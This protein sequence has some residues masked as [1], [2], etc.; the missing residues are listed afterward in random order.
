MKYILT[1]LFAVILFGAGCDTEVAT[2]PKQFPQ[3]A[4]R[5]VEDPEESIAPLSDFMDRRSITYN[6]GR[7]VNFLVIK[8]DQEEFSW[9]M[10]ED[11]SAPKT[12]MAW[13]QA[14]AANLVINGSYFDEL[15]QSTG[16]YHA[17]EATSTRI[18]WP[19]RDS[20]SDKVSYTGLVQ[21][22]NDELK[23][24]YLPNGWQKEA[25]PDVAAFLSFPTLINDG[26]S[27]VETDSGKFAH[28]TVLVQDMNDVPYIVITESGS[29]TLFELAK[30]LTDQ[31]ED[32]K[33]A[34]NL[35]GGPSTGMSYA[36]EDNKVEVLSASVP[37][38]LY[39]KKNDN[40]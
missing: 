11:I 9:G 33:V 22:I 20:Q 4:N 12:V 6:D 5:I 13:R 30:W 38:V 10:A 31:P 32:F 26:A 34:I 25:A 8:I 36:D 23:L 19:S 39:L 24:S 27:L 40:R 28:R 18:A 35:D 7:V 21:I 29:P 3:P 15:M 2:A 14:L 17:A 16:Y 1:L 37:N